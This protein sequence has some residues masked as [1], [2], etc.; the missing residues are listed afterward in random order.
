MQNSQA[1]KLKLQLEEARNNT[2]GDIVHKFAK[3]LINLPPGGS[4]ISYFLETYVKEPASQR[5]ETFLHSLVDMLLEI[6][7]KV[8]NLSLDSPTFQTA[9]L[10]VLS[11]AHL[12]HQEQELEAL[13]NI[14]VNAALPNAPE[15]D[16]QKMFLNWA[17]GFTTS[18]LMLLKY[19][20][21]C[22]Y[23]T[24]QRL[25]QDVD[26]KGIFYNQVLQDLHTKSLIRLREVYKAQEKNPNYRDHFS[27]GT[28]IFAST[29]SSFESPY[30]DSDINVTK[31]VENITNIIGVST[32][33][34]E[35]NQTTFRPKRV[36]DLGKLF[37]EFIKNPLERINFNPS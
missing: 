8:E 34:F 27:L 11:I 21:E 36:T 22:D 17:D 10:S 15:A 31:R 13:R 32:S 37:L 28:Q 30:R 12:H 33:Y 1:H 7:N 23:D 19:L 9:L 3:A 29:I 6:E 24:F 18:H 25:R 26:K 4:L 5:L 20:D 2:N 14:V 16:T 35:Q